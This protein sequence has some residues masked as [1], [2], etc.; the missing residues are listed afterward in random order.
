MGKDDSYAEKAIISVFTLFLYV[1]SLCSGRRDGYRK[2]DDYRQSC[3]DRRPRRSA[4]WE[5]K[6]L[7]SVGWDGR[8]GGYVTV[9]SKRCAVNEPSPAG[10]EAA[11]A[12]V[13]GV[14]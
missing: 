9:S 7:F 12:G 13:N 6:E 3:R 4:R 1:Y 2:V 14:L 5:C 10:S 8:I 11:T